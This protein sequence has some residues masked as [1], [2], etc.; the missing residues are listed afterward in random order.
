MLL[1]SNVIGKGSQTLVILHGFL[2]MSDNWK[3]YAKNISAFGFEVHLIDQRNH[4]KSFHS[5]DFSYDLMAK[6]L[7]NYLDFNKLRDISL[8]GHSMGGKTAMQFSSLFPSLVKKLVVVDILPIHYKSNFNRI[9]NSLKS[10]DLNVIESRKEANEVLEKTIKEESLRGFLLKNLFRNAHK[11]LQFKFN[12]NV[13][14]N[15]FNEVESA[16]KIPLPFHGDTLFIKGENSNYI[17]ELDMLKA[18]K[19]FPNSN[20]VSIVNSGHWVHAENP[21]KFLEETI[22]FLKY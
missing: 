14:F 1:K 21:N 20:L 4:G 9:L 5:N 6:D 18:K 16:L 11:K 13:L 7:K 15:K 3:S 2:G 19:N 22:K 10:I 12:L 17:N 8:I